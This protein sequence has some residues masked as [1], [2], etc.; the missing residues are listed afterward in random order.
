MKMMK[1][2]MSVEAELDFK[3][4]HAIFHM[5]VVSCSPNVC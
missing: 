2:S 4:Y 1:V 3:K 5:I